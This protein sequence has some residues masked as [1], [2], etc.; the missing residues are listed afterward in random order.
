M[1]LAGYKL[2]QRTSLEF[3]SGHDP[4]LQT[5]MVRSSILCPPLFSAMYA[6]NLIYVSVFTGVCQDSRGEKGES[7]S[8][9]LWFASSSQNTRESVSHE[10]I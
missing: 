3:D 7:E 4:R 1:E 6:V 2:L 8:F 5:Q 9:L 10:W